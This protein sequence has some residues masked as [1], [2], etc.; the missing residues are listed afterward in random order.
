MT[1][2]TKQGL[3]P[4]DPVASELAARV[5]K[6]AAN[7][8]MD[9][10]VA[11]A[12]I[13]EACRDIVSP[14]QARNAQLTQLCKVFLAIMDPATY[15]DGQG[16]YKARIGDLFAKIEAVLGGPARSKKAEAGL[17]WT[18]DGVSIVRDKDGEWPD[19]WYVADDGLAYTH[20]P[21]RDEDV[22]K[23]FF[24]REAAEKAKGQ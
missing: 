9:A 23:M 4:N 15:G 18:A 2:A 3:Y 8:D 6:I 16:K 1:P 11:G 7:R 13:A 14:I 21:W 19:L 17:H 22:G 24:A 5:L 12:L 10:I 20:R